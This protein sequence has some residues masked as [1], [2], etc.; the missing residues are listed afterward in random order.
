MFVLLDLIAICNSG[1]SKNYNHRYTLQ[2]RFYL[3]LI[4]LITVNDNY[5]LL[6]KIFTANRIIYPK[7]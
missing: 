2:W 5:L 4:K 3:P 7:Q 1:S 6:I